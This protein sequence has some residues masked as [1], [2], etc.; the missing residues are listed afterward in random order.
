MGFIRNL[1]AV[2]S[3][4]GVKMLSIALL[5]LGVA[6]F[7]NGP[8]WAQG[9]LSSA[10][11]EGIVDHVSNANIKVT[12]PQTKQ[13]LSFLI[14]PRFDQ[15]VSPDGRR[16]YRLKD[17]VPGRFVRIYFDQQLLGQRRADRIVLLRRDRAVPRTR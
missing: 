12:N 10:E 8:A 11:F 9:K 14:G 16:T 17:V 13:T 4:A 6:G 7:A 3:R 2:R 1:I 15:I 5:M